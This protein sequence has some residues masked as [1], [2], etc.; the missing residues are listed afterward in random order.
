VNVEKEVT[1]H[2]AEKPAKGL[3]RQMEDREMK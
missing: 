2:A 1:R 3:A